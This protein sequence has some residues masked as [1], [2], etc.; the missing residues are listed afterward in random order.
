[1]KKNIVVFCFFTYL[2]LSGS[3]CFAQSVGFNK[4]KEIAK[5]HLIIVSKNNLKSASSKKANFQFNSAKVA[6]ENKD[7]LYYILNDTINKGFV[8]VSADQRAWPILGY[9]L[10]GIYNEKKQP[11]AFVAWMDAREKEIAYIKAND[12]QTD[13]QT[14]AAW[15]QLKSATITTQSNGV[16]PLLTTKWDQG[17]YYNEQCP[18]FETA[19]CGGHAPT[20]CVATAMAQIMKYWNYPTTGKGSHSYELPDYGTINADF[21]STTYQWSQMPNI[22]TEKNEAVAT[23]MFHC[24]VAVEMYYSS[25]I[26]GANEPSKALV[27][28]F[29][30]SPNIEYIIRDDYSKEDFINL[31]KDELNLGHPIYY[32]F[33]TPIT[34]ALI[35]DGYQDAEYFHFNWGWGGS[36]DGYFYIGNMNKVFDDNNSNTLTDRAII[37]IFPNKL[38]DGY[39]GIFLSANK[40]NLDAK[41]GVKPGIPVTIASSANWTVTCDKS[42]VTLSSSSGNSGNSILTLTVTENHDVSP[43]TA[44]VTVS[45]EG[46][47]PQMLT[48]N[49]LQVL[50]VEAGGLHNLILNDLA[51]ITNLTLDGTMDARDFRTLRDEMPKLAKLDLSGVQ[52]V[53]YTGIDGTAVENTDAGVKPS[54]NVTTYP[55]DVLP[56]SAFRFFYNSPDLKP[57][58]KSVILPSSITT[59]GQEAFFNCRGL[60]SV[61][62]PTSVVEIEHSAFYNCRQLASVDFPPSLTSIGYSSFFSCDHLFPGTIPSTVA[63]IGTGSFANIKGK[64]T[65]DP[66][67]PNYSSLDGVLYSKDKTRLMQC[68]TSVVGNFTIPSIVKTIEPYAFLGDYNLTSVIIGYFGD[69][70]PLFR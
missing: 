15:E 17:C 31:L 61:I 30:Y 55:E 4:A 14:V 10:Q 41:E 60:I 65:V 58:L 16:G 62:I 11:D 33:Y 12:L 54:I 24:G 51:T 56:I 13:L 20:G 39:N 28:Y 59:I 2:I 64:I 35:C 43:R 46:F 49:Q 18:S 29:D 32:E 70:D 37:K 47:S 8:I 27:D 44:I 57:R 63:L 48:V 9:S 19:Y 66:N 25:Y 6:V 50:N 53:G 42:W 26:S 1:M 3:L 38:P 36:S 23:L 21:G 22:V 68:P 52:V 7:T 40:L 34:H 5:N 69:A 45:A 67:N